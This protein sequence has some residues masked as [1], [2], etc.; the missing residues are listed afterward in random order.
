MTSAHPEKPSERVA[1]IFMTGVD[2]TVS[3]ITKADLLA[4][5]ERLSKEA[6]ELVAKA[7]KPEEKQRLLDASLYLQRSVS[8]ARHIK[9]RLGEV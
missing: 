1:D 5:L 2:C 3:P 4:E 9:E 8:C 7:R 6:Q